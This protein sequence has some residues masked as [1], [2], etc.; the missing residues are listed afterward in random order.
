MKIA[1]SG[2][3]GSGKTLF[4][5]CLGILVARKKQVYM[6]DAD[7]DGNLGLTLGFSEND[8]KQLSPIV[9]LKELIKERTSSDGSGLYKLNPEVSDIPEKYSLKKNNI[10]LLVLGEVKKA[11]SGCYC[12]ENAFL[13][14][15]LRHLILRQEEVVIVD[16]PAGIEHLTRGT[17]GGIDI[18]Y[19]MVEPTSKSVQTAKRILALAKEL[20]ISQCVIVGNKI[21]AEHDVDFLKNT[22]TLEP[23]FC[24]KNDI[25]LLK[26]E[27]N[28]ISLDRTQFFHQIKDLLST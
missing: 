24:I 15:L 12:P 8:L 16:M 17:A 23:Q 9:T 28:E 7:P 26:F 10:R 18:L 5:A 6:I 22:L 21:Q 27:Q 1:V 3:G 14:A 2:K 11:S 13:K 4:S 20:G 25:S 19:I